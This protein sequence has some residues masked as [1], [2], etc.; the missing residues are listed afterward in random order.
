[1]SENALDEGGT[2]MRAG[3]RATATA[4]RHLPD[5]D[6]SQEKDK[7][8]TIVALEELATTLETAL[9]RVQ[10]LHEQQRTAVAA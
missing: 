5:R 1:M 7:D 6:G 4:R 9:S 10:K 2:K 8:E 3:A